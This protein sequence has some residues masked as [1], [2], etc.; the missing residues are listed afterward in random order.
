M[1]LAWVKFIIS[2]V[3]GVSA[4]VCSGL[5]IYFAPNLWYFIRRKFSGRNPSGRRPSEKPINLWILFWMSV[6]LTILTPAIGS[7][8]PDAL[9]TQTLPP[10]MPSLALTPTYP[11]TATP[12]VI[13][14][15]A[16]TI[17]ETWT[18]SVTPKPTQTDTPAPTNTP[19][20]IDYI[21]HGELLEMAP[22]LRDG[23]DYWNFKN[24]SGEGFSSSPNKNGSTFY[25]YT[26]FACAHNGSLGLQ[27]DYLIREPDFAAWGLEWTASQARYFDA[28]TFTNVV[29]WVKGNTGNNPFQIAL[30]SQDENSHRLY[31]RNYPI[32]VAPD[33]WTKVEIPLSDFK[34]V[35]LSAVTH[36]GVGIFYAENGPGSI[37]IDDIAFE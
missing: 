26:S 9:P 19:I 15:Y 13:P 20:A 31:L 8:L 27:V 22:Q 18:P 1:S 35:D 33:A 3:F 11:S 28:S 2:V 16:S 37:C 24:L 36:L 6:V 17:T 23:S 10:T 5:L 29:F 21:E 25:F 30:R 34:G 14:T 7:S 12:N 4:L 32:V